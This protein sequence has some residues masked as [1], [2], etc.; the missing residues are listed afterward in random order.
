MGRMT[1]I[2][3]DLTE[4]LTIQ[5]AMMGPKLIMLYVIIIII[6]IIITI[7]ITIM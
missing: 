2:V 1:G 4:V 3:K 7:T 5:K 6:I